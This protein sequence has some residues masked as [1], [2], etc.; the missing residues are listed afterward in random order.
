MAIR[1]SQEA[2]PMLNGFKNPGR[3]ALIGAKSE[4]GLAIV[5]Q[6]PEDKSREVILVGRSGDYALDVTDRAARERVF[7]AIFDKGDLD[8]AIIA[9]GVLGNNPDK[10]DTENLVEAMGV[11][12]LGSVHLLALIAERMKIQAHGTILVI[13]SFAQVRPRDD[14]FAYGSTKAG[15]DFYARGLSAK[16]QGSGV[17]IKILRPG[18]VKSK[19]TAGMAIAPFSIT[20]EEC[21]QYGVRAISSKKVVTWAP[22]ILKY[23]AMV[24]ATMPPAIFRKISQR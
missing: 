5:S 18:F 24:F 14:N 21:A 1:S 12:Y 17:K 7:E 10:S 23:V 20:T 8:L 16:L 19:M 13:S 6:L 22:S 9:V 3:I 15:L 4:I 2:S 11:N